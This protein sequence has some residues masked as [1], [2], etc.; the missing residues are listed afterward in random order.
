MSAGLSMATRIR[1][2]S[3]IFSLEMNV[4]KSC[5]CCVEL[6]SVPS[7]ADVDHINAV[8]PG[9]PDIRLHV[10][11]QILAAKMALCTQQHLNILCRSIEHRREVVWGHLD[12]D[13]RFIWSERT[14]L[15]EL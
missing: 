1:A 5:L 11:L 14:V 4:S 13:M 8:R 6:P 15:T 7:L 3:T 2:A 12:S 10:R 9:L